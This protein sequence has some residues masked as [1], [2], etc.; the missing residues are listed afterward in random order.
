MSKQ[1]KFQAKKPVPAKSKT[2]KAAAKPGVL[3]RLDATFE[4]NEKKIFYILLTISTLFSFLLFDSKVSTGGDD[5]AYIER[6]WQ[7]L[8]EGIFP[9]FQGP[10]YPVFLS[11]FVKLFGLNVIVLKLSSVLCQFGFVWFTYK[12]F[13]KRIPYSVLFALISFVSFNTFFQ[14]YASQTYTET[15]FLFIQSVCLYIIFNI[16]DSI[17]PEN[18]LLTEVKKDYPKWLLFGFM[19][20]VLSLSKSIAFVSIVAVVFYFL[21]NKNFKQ[22][23]YALIA[24][25]IFRIIYQLGTAAAFGANDSGQLELLLRKDLYKPELGHED[26]SGMI[27]RFMS[28]FKLYFSLHMYRIFNIRSVDDIKVYP[29]ISY[30]SGIVLAVF[31]FISYRKNKFVF[32]SG[33]YVLMLC[34]GVFFAIQANNMQ[35]RLIMIAMP[36]LF[37]VLFYGVYELARRS[38]TLQYLVLLFAA[39]M[40]LITVGKSVIQA[41]KNTTALSKNLSGDI[42]FGYTPDWVNFLQ[43]SRYCA[44]SLPVNE[45][46][47]IISRKPEMSFIYGRGRKFIGQYWVPTMNADSILMGWQQE[48]V[49]YVIMPSLRM[50]PK[51]NNGRI[52]N[53]LQRMIQPIQMKYPQKLKL[54]KTIGTDE[55]AY[56]YEISY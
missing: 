56:L 29:G 55:A 52:I 43:M 51:K 47:Q 4:K 21:L 13:R 24:F 10:G 1:Q 2:T 12:A 45:N 34:G 46:A 25:G 7:L 26:F 41:Q 19:F 8:H 37:L 53:T 9:Y 32:F 49:K 22:I 16:I 3:Q 36:L 30:L 15:F 6:A 39:V 5:S 11:L 54:L 23:L 14:Y 50:E 48:K 17:K 38:G 42:Y 31:T 28:N 35:D 27:T 40:I 44:D 33:I 18:G 20:L